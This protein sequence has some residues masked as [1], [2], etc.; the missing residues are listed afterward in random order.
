MIIIGVDP[1]K[2]TGIA[3][4]QSP[5]AR[6]TH[7][8][9]VAQ[10]T[11]PWTVAEVGP[12]EVL[13]CIRG[14]LLGRRPRLIACERFIQGTGRRPMSYQGDAQHITGEV[15]ALA[16][17]LEC[18]FVRQLPGPAKKIASN[19]VLKRIGAYTGTPDGHGDDACRQVIRA[20]A[21]NFPEVFA[22]LIGI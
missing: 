6:L 19:A 8:G 11:Q 3:M 9:A 1:G 21:D 7:N 18:P 22:D 17:V 12:T 16:Q 10:N 13:S 4:W 20:L 5:E 15:S 2:I 14:M